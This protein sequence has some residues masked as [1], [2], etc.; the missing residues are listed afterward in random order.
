MED[1]ETE[2]KVQ[3]LRAQVGMTLSGHGLNF[4]YE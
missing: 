3:R 1:E 2:D 4:L